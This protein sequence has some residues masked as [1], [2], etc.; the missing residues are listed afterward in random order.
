MHWIFSLYVAFLFFI[1]TPAILVR[2]PPKAGKFTVAGFHAVVF[3]LILHFTGKIVLNFSR[4]LEGFQEG[5]NYT[6]QQV[7]GS[8]NTTLA[9]KFCT[10]GTVNP[11]TNT[12]SI[13][14]RRWTT[15][16]CFDA[17]NNVIWT[18]ARNNNGSWNDWNPANN[19]GSVECK[20]GKSANN[21]CQ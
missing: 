18:N 8:G 5:I 20:N 10:K 15:P 14:G 17:S 7:T 19:I 4:S 16:S 9:G 3:A 11:G 21:S 1:L 12:P 6:Q 2:L 13:S